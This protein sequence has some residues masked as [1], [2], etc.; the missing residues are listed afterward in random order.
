MS[1][2]Q[3]DKEGYDEKLRLD[4]FSPI[5]KI[6]YEYKLRLTKESGL[7]NGKVL[8]QSNQDLRFARGT[9]SSSALFISLS[10]FDR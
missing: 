4:H 8:K 10:I 7:G 5:V 2:L 3:I 9:L 6:E 1:T